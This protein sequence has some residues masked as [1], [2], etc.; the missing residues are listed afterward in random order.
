MST[1]E[2]TLTRSNFLAA[3]L[4]LDAAMEANGGLV[5]IQSTVYQ[6]FFTH[7]VEI[8]SGLTDIA[9]EVP[10]PTIKT[11]L[12]GHV[13]EDIQEAPF[14]KYLDHEDW[15]SNLPGYPVPAATFITQDSEEDS[16]ADSEDDSEEESDVDSDYVDSV[17]STDEDHNDLASDY[18]TDPDDE[19][20]EC[21]CPHC[22]ASGPHKPAVFAAACQAIENAPGNDPA[23]GRFYWIWDSVDAAQI[24]PWGF[25]A[26]HVTDA[27]TKSLLLREF[28]GAYDP[29]TSL[30][31]KDSHAVF[32]PELIHDCGTAFVEAM[33]KTHLES[34]SDRY[35]SNDHAGAGESVFMYI[36]DNLKRAKVDVPQYLSH[37]LA[38]PH[39][40]PQ[41]VV[42]RP[43][44]FSILVANAHRSP[45]SISVK[46]DT[47]Y[48]RFRMIN[49]AE[50]LVGH[51]YGPLINK[52]TVVDVADV[53]H[54]RCPN[55]WCDFDEVVP[56][57]ATSSVVKTPCK[58]I[59][60]ASCLLES[61]KA[62]QHFRCPMC[63]Q[64][65]ATLVRQAAA[66]TVPV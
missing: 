2:I 63:H 30:R 60:H 37:W 28:F 31:V 6:V 26:A 34:L 15:P 19:E 36:L 66:D 45:M 56:D 23:W 41:D 18:D 4:A 53:A 44:I 59:F 64:D 42:D 9:A 65:I 24:D 25:M 55:C 8:R 3:G 29:E 38:Q 58:H 10:G 11:W 51:K 14:L 39:T 21:I 57:V 1:S 52:L 20:A 47:V 61:F 43:Y 12:N 13:P 49:R 62:A 27:M 54:E 40:V 7:V 50:R 35:A 46:I 33:Y 32:S 5:D 17:Y 16:E 48:H 22:A